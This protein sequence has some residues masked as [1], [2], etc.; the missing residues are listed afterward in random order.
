MINTILIDLDNTIID[1]NHL[2]E[3]SFNQVFNENG[4][5]IK[6]SYLD[7]Q[8][9]STV[10]ILKA[11]LK[12]NCD[13]K[14]LS[15][16]KNEIYISKLRSEG[17]NF[18]PY[19]KEFL[20]L[21]EKMNCQV[22]LTTAAS[23]NSV[24]EVGKIINWPLVFKDFILVSDVGYSKTNS[25]FWNIIKTKIANDLNRTIVIDDMEKVLLAAR[26]AKY[27]NLVHTQSIN[28]TKNLSQGG[29]HYVNHLM[30]IV[31]I[32]TIGGGY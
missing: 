22:Y 27:P 18:L 9:Y 6:W 30:E 32:Y 20:Y 12:D 23:K 13:V 2:H 8:G 31:E 29:I 5:D 7:Y 28:V 11:F 1:S 24:I 19:A 3:Q 17:L 4:L 21:I 25:K 14:N 26:D 16:R 10:E 15:T